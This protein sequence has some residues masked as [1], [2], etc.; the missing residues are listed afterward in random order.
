VWILLTLLTAV[1]TSLRDVAQKQAGRRADPV[2]V[3]LGVAAVPAVGLGAIALALGPPSLGAGFGL[4]LL[5]SGGINIVATPLVVWALQR[6]D[7]SLVAPLT[8]LTPLFMIA[9][10]AVVLGEMPDARGVAGVAII[11]AGA[12]LLTLTDPAAGP[13][14]PLRALLRDAGARA[15]LLVAFLY[16]FSATF[17]KVGT[18]ASSPIVWAASI[19]V[20]VAVVMAPLALRRLVRAAER[21]GRVQ[22]PRGWA[23][24]EGGSPATV[25]ANAVPLRAWHPAGTFGPLL[26]ILLAG[27][28]TAIAAAAQMTAL[29]MTLAA[30]VIAV[31]RTSTLFSVFLGHSVF[32][33]ENIRARLLGAAV[34]LGGFVVLVLR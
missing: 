33:E 15:M 6:S 8:S 31:K 27:T 14:A 23:R 13:L 30:F 20:V 19:H 17:D 10:G 3:A 21:R 22:P 2:V 25:P 34:M 12:Y 7:L 29:T 16:S 5:V 18:Q 26:A 32:G 9:T 1:C 24:G 4:A 28:F 11:A